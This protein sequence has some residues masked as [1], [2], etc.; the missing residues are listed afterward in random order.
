MIFGLTS[1][2]VIGFDNVP[3]LSDNGQNIMKW[4]PICVLISFLTF[5]AI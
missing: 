3:L 2:K 4:Q 5:L 1:F